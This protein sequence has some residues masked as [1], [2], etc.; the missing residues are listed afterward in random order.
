MHHIANIQQANSVF[1]RI[2]FIRK[3]P[4]KLFRLVHTVFYFDIAFMASE[5]SFA[6]QFVLQLPNPF[7]ISENI[8]RSMNINYSPLYQ[9]VVRKPYCVSKLIQ[10]FP[11]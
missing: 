7:I 2:P 8:F 6:S 5:K 11:R 4:C 3:S 10:I 1:L 9:I